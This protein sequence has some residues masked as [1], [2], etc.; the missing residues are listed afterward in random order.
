[1]PAGTC[2]G[3]GTSATSTTPGGEQRTSTGPGSQVIALAATSR[4]HDITPHSSGG[5]GGSGRLPLQEA[6]AF[7]WFMSCCRRRR[8]SCIAC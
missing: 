8:I 3:S 2:G 4:C 1:V 5:S 7:E 6:V